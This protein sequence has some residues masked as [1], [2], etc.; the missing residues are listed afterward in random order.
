MVTSGGNPN[1]PVANRIF[2]DISEGAAAAVLLVA[3]GLQ[4]L[5]AVSI[6]AGLCR[7]VYYC[8]WLVL[9]WLKRCVS[10]PYLAATNKPS[11]RR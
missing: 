9:A 7:R 10:N 3:G 2:W 1:P 5:Q 6:S 8:C 4:A 11:R